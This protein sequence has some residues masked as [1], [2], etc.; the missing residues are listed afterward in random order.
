[1]KLSKKDHSLDT[2]REMYQ[3]SCNLESSSYT[4]DSKV[5][6]NNK[7]TSFENTLNSAQLKNNKHL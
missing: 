4:N 5:L 6:T 1:M 7:F 3:L 2:E